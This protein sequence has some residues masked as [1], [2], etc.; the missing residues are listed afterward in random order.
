MDCVD[1]IKQA[2]KSISDAASELT[3]DFRSKTR[4]AKSKLLSITKTLKRRSG[5]SKTEVRKIT[6][7]MADIVLE[8]AKSAKRILKRALQNPDKVDSQLSNKLQNII[9]TTEK[10]VEQA[11]AVNEGNTNLKDRLIS[12]HD[13]DA[14]PIKKGKLG[15]KVEFGYKL[16]ISENGDGIITNYELYKGNPSDDAL[17]ADAIKQHIELFGRAPMTVAADRGYGSKNNEEYCASIGVKNICIPR[18][19]K[20]NKV[21]TET[22]SKQ[23]FKKYQR[24]RAGIEGRISYLKRCFGLARLRV[25]GYSVSK[26]VV[27]WAILTHNLIKA[28]KM[29]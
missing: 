27:G 26:T 15:K 16:Q 21:Q 22:E 23:T 24:W 4:T 19:G 10:I 18:R 13:Q 6:D 8:A 7:E 3:E 9:K 5:D 20:K 1:G 29:A 17:L 25:R 28:V 12:I 11:K 14:R 2:V